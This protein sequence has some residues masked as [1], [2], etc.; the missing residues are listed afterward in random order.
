M[1]IRTKVA[2]GTGFMFI[3]L[4]V[5]SL[6][7][8]YSSYTIATTG[9]SLFVDNALSIEYTENILSGLDLL[10]D[11]TT[12]ADE[13]DA[14]LRMI[15]DNIVMEERN[16]TESGERDHVRQLKTGMILLD[17]AYAKVKSGDPVKAMTGFR[18]T[19]VIVSREMITSVRAINRLNLEA[20]RRENGDIAAYES[21]F[22]INLSIIATIF[23]L[24]SFSFLFN[25]PSIVYGGNTPHRR[26]R[27]SRDDSDSGDDEGKNN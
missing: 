22:Y 2:I 10:T 17:A 11:R 12:T 5:V 25:F 26:D 3:Q 6:F 8:L 21:R 15:R 4:L 27:I 20:I 13:A 14:A 16:I 24:V 9:K 19:A 18:G 23:L 7:G 1:T